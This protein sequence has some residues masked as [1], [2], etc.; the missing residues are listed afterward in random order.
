MQANH[1]LP[2]SKQRKTLLPFSLTSA[3]PV[4]GAEGTLSSNIP[5]F[6]RLRFCSPPSRHTAPLDPGNCIYC[7]AEGKHK[8]K[9]NSLGERSDQ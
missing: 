1:H 6:P 5:A 9:K 3:C 4:A 7:K 2:M 8:I